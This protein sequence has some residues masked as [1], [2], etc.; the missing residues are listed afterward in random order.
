MSKL[1]VVAVGISLG[2]AIGTTV[3]IQQNLPREAQAAPVTLSPLQ[4]HLRYLDAGSL[5]VEEAPLP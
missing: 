3:A 2:L 5:P 1:L 4:M